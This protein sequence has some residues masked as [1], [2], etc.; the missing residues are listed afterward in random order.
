MSDSKND[1]AWNY[2]F[3][4]YKIVENIRCNGKFEI[5]ANQI[6]E[7]KREPRLMTKFDYKSQ[8]PTLFLKHNLSI[9]P[10]SRGSYVISDVETFLKFDENEVEVVRVE[11]PAYLETIDYNNLS[12]G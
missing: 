11:F 7:S 9:L 2:I 1:V 8:L 4:K 5:N 3:E 10:I 6:K 12:S